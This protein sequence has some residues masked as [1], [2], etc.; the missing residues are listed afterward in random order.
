MFARIRKKS[1]L[2][3]VA[4]AKL[5]SD[6][7][8]FLNFEEEIIKIMIKKIILS[9]V[10]FLVVAQLFRVDTTNPPLTPENDFITVVKAPEE[11]GQI[12]K[13]ACY[14]CHSNE[15]AYPWYFNVAPAS[16]WLKN[17]INEGRRKLNFSTWSDYTAKRK[18]KKM[19]ES[20]KMIQEGEMPL[21]SYTLVHR[22]AVLSSEQQKM[23]AD[24][25]SS[26]QEK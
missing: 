26:I 10:V 2:D 4:E 7:V 15:T 18:D 6:S 17:H 3:E 21:S 24:F 11:V 23:L 22:D 8:I 5:R 25:F 16:W 9:A 14:D 20:A 12:I 19:K 1:T 13:T